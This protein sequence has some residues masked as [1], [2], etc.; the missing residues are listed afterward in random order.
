MELLGLVTD[1]E[2]NFFCS[3][4]AT[5]PKIHK[6]KTPR[7]YLIVRLQLRA[8]SQRS[9]AKSLIGRSIGIIRASLESVR[10]A[11]GEG[12]LLEALDTE[13]KQPTLALFQ[14]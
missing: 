9:T 8:D 2:H 13:R 5:K 6:C 1:S 4:S 14:E 12:K 3:P 7:S 10:E 11:F